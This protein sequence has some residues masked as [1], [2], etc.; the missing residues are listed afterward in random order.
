MALTDYSGLKAAVASWLN[1]TDLTAQI[2]DFISATEAV[3]GRA[4][5]VRR[6]VGRTSVTIDAEYEDM[7]ADFA[8]EIGFTL[9]DWPEPL[10]YLTA[11][12]MD[13]KASGSSGTTS[14]P[15]WF[16]IYGDQFRFFPV[17]DQ[18]YAASLTYYQKLPALSDSNTTNW[19][20]DDH[21]DVYLYG[22]LVEASPYLRDDERLPL[23]AA[24]FERAL[25]DIKTASIVESY[26]SRR[27]DFPL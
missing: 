21:P 26:G 24:R 12:Q 23:F 11:A 1:R 5:R 6:M 27:P 3:V 10:T 2:P 25:Q 17:P 22:A 19:L 13:E 7:P 4:L 20:L 8:G 18:S 15:G 9:T 14:R 16:S